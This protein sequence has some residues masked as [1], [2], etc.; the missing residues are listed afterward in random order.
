MVD[1]SAVVRRTVSELVSGDPRISVESA[2][3]PIFAW[4]MMQNAWP[5]L[6]LLD[7]NMPRMDGLTFLKKIM[8]ERPTP[9]VVCSSLARENAPHA[10]EALRSGALDVIAKPDIGVKDF[11]ESSRHR[12]LNMVHELSRAHVLQPTPPASLRP[13][14][15]ERGKRFK[16][17]AIG[18]STGGTQALEHILSSL[19]ED[20][21]GL[22]IVQ[23]MPAKFTFT[24]AERLNQNSQLN[25]R[26][27]KNGDRV[28][29]GCALI[30][31]GG[32]HMKLNSQGSDL[33]VEVKG[34]P[35]VNRHKPSVNVL[36]RSVAEVCGER[37]T[38]ILLTGMGDDGAEGLLGMR[39]A[40]AFTIAQDRESSAVY[41]M[42]QECSL[43]TI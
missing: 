14:P 3:D 13:S 6:V 39:K 24:F 1:D 37:S 21:P 40:G 20:A 30:A 16:V 41:G 5:D 9:V 26:E 38:G 31:P 15:G 8:A 42:P 18:A 7:I 23:H 22:L 17:V 36:F 11:L 10:V 25:V 28:L 29:K 19:T 33:K 27:A 32:F 2:R 43:W 4:D 34:G 35:P 12:F